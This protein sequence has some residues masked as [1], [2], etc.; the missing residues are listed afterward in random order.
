MTTLNLQ[1]AASTD[2]GHYGISP[3]SYY[4]A[5]AGNCLS[6]TL[7]TNAYGSWHRFTGVSG[8][9]GA[10]IDSA[11]L[12]FWAF[13]A[14]VGTPLTK[15]RAERANAP[16]APTS[17]SDAE[18]R[19]KTT[20][21]VDWDDPNLSTSGYTSKDIT[22]V[23]QELADNQ[24]PSVIIIY[25]ENDGPTG[26]SHYAQSVGYDSNPART[27]KLTITYATSVTHEA[28]AALSAAATLSPAAGLL[29]TPGAS[30]AASA[31]LSPLATGEVLAAAALPTSG[32]LA[33]DGNL[34]VIFAASALV[35]SVALAALAAP[36]VKTAAAALAASALLT[37]SATRIAPIKTVSLGAGMT[38]SLRQRGGVAY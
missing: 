8:L 32:T 29:L 34:G 22:S 7:S 5:T 15:I 35:G 18:S 9:A 12:E 17:Q 25:W 33:A 2:D 36:L 19:T 11:V 27:A 37:A 31:T 30:L 23:I 1:V 24:N 13:A 10:I 16:S 26:T 38:S 20:A 14:D 4:D 3:T 28:A 21:K 6:G